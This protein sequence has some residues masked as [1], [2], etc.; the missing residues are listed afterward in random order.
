[1]QDKKLES[2]A[3]EEDE[4]V[5]VPTRKYVKD[6][7][8]NHALSRN[9][10]YATQVEP[11]FVTLSNDVDSDSERTVATSKAVKAVYDLA[12]ANQNA[13]NSHIGD[14]SLPV[15]VP[16]PW[17]TENPPEGWLICNGDSF[18]TAKYLKL[19]LAYP[20]GV[21]PD[22]R[23]EFIRGLDNG[24]GIDPSRQIL[25]QQADN[26]KKIQLAEGNGV[27]YLNIYQG[28]LNN[29]SFPIGR[30]MTGNATKTSIANNTGGDETRP[31]NIAFN[32]I[33]R[34]A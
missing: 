28:H 8:Q 29:L 30:D 18:D 16:V 15:G 19:A 12:T 32:Y 7:I 20:S 2:K 31:R 34:A 25:S 24:R 33:V 6:S 17:P 21:L 13:I 10:P 27:D 5:I 14:F 26:T 1:M 9:H 11:G 3:L 23:G 4:V 22:L